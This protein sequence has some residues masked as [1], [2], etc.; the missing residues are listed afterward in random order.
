MERKQFMTQRVAAYQNNYFLLVRIFRESKILTAN[1]CSTVYDSSRHCTK[2]S[3]A[4][5]IAKIEYNSLASE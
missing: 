1:T 5:K 3:K 2:T 4:R